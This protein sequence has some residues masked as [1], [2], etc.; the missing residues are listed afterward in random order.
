[1]ADRRS[2]VDCVFLNSGIQRSLN[3]AKPES[4]DLDCVG[5]ELTTNYISYIHV[6]YFLPF[7]QRQ[8]SPTSL[9]FTTSALAL[10]PI[11]HCP[12]YYASKAAIHHLILAMRVQLEGS[13]VKVI[14]ILPAG[15]ADGVA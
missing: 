3:F 13:N 6:T 12:N 1:M 8:S 4:I 2:Q 5:V 15:S 10:V 9:I 7:V 11:T 14:E